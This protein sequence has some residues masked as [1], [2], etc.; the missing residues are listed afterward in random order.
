VAWRGDAWRGDGR[1]WRDARFR[2][3]SSFGVAVGFADPYY[4]YGYADPNYS[5]GYAE[6]YDSYA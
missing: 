4:S 2:S 3:R 5:Y 6:P 1:Y